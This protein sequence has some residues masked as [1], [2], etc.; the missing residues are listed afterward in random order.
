MHDHG[1]LIN[2]HN[3]MARIAIYGAYKDELKLS[4]KSKIRA[5]FEL[6]MFDLILA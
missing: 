3:I 5:W 2:R 4:L 1:N 6:R